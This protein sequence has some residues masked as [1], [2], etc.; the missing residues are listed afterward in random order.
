M[1]RK[2]ITH[3]AIFHTVGSSTDM[4]LYY[5]DGKREVLSQLSIE[6]ATYIIDLLRNEKPWDYDVESHMLMSADLEPIGEEE[7]QW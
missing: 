3:Y 7:R 1:T 6:E 5:N 2:R 4:T